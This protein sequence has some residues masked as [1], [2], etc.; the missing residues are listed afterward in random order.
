MIWSLSD[1]ILTGCIMCY[2]F[3]VDEDYNRMVLGELFQH[4]KV[5]GKDI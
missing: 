1:N 4:L 3:I 5:L 2:L